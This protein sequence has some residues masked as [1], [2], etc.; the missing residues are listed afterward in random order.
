MHAILNNH[1]LSQHDDG[2]DK[3]LHEQIIWLSKLL[4]V[5]LYFGLQDISAAA[6]MDGSTCSVFY[7]E[8]CLCWLHAA[9]R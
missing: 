7:S 8:S 1:D 2:L 5:L 6:E 9:A 3:C 4:F